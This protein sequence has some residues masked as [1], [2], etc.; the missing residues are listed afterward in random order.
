MLGCLPPDTTT[1][2]ARQLDIIMLDSAKRAMGITETALHPWT[3]TRMR[4]TS[5]RGGTALVSHVATAPQAYLAMIHRVAP[6]L[7]GYIDTADENKTWPGILPASTATQWQD[8]P[9]TFAPS[10][11]DGRFEAV[12]TNDP[13]GMGSEITRLWTYLK[14]Q[15]A[16]TDGPLSG[17][18]T[19]MGTHNGRLVNKFQNRLTQQRQ[20][21]AFFALPA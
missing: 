2:H 15:T 18:A 11:V 1:Q 19:S 17:P 21:A 20:D 10:T 3:L 13:A 7:V 6:L 9:D 16:S 14:T 8:G 4:L 12:V 5:K